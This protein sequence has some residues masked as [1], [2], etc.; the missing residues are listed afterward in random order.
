MLRNPLKGF[1]GLVN[2]CVCVYKKNLGLYVKR[3]LLANNPGNLPIIKNYLSQ[4]LIINFVS[5][6][7]YNSWIPQSAIL[8]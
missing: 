8:T 2:D 4:G 6:F 7:V 5:D 3:K 1:H